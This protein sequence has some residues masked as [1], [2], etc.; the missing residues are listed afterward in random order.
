MI[1]KLIIKQ[2]KKFKRTKEVKDWEK[3]GKIPPTPQLIK[4]EVVK[5]YAKNYNIDTFIET[6]TYMGDMVEAV[7]DIF[8]EIYSVELSKELFDKCEKRFP[9]NFPSVD[10]KINLFCGDSAKILPKML[11]ISSSKKTRKLRGLFWLDAHY[12]G[13]E[14]AHADLQTPIVEE[15]KIILNDN[16]KHIILIDDARLFDG[17]NDYPKIKTIFNYISSFGK[18]MNITDDIIRIT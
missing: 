15:L 4:Q 1:T 3:Q 2:L 8:K 18:N 17:T 6:G 11:A 10:K 5:E 16:P 12:S 13:G 9:T 14:T 7:K